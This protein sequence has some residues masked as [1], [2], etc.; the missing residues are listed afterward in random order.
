V[1]G[2]CHENPMLKLQQLSTPFFPEADRYSL[3][4][5]SCRVGNPGS[6]EADPGEEV[7]FNFWGGRKCVIISLTIRLLLLTIK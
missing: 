1:V 4:G 5:F 6:S 2:L 3:L 7:I